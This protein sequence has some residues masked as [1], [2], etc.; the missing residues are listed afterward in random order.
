MSKQASTDDMSPKMGAED[1]LLG[2]KM[3]PENQSEAA[4]Q[5]VSLP[6]INQKMQGMASSRSDPAL[7]LANFSNEQISAPAVPNHL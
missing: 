6:D 1:G 4:K 2:A 3:A 7:N 5:G